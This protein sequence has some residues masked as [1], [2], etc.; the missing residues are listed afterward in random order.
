MLNKGGEGKLGAWCSSLDFYRFC[1]WKVD[2]SCKHSFYR[3]TETHPQSISYFGV[4]SEFMIKKAFNLC[5]FLSHCRAMLRRESF[6]VFVL[7]RVW[8]Y[9]FMYLFTWSVCWAASQFWYINN[10]VTQKTQFCQFFGQHLVSTISSLYAY[11]SI[12]WKR[13]LPEDSCFC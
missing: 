7:E 2:G 13:S 5:G 8:I 3:G 4:G 1:T 12:I 6:N 9:V 11:P 10:S